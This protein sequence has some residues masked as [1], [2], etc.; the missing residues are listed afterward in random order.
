LLY[1]ARKRTGDARPAELEG[2]RDMVREH[3]G[4][5]RTWADRMTQK[6]GNDVWPGNPDRLRG[7]AKAAEKRI[8]N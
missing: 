8:A 5:L 1:Q 6:H 7:F 3:A 4:A 2:I